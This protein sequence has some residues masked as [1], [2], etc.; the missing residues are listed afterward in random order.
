MSILSWVL[1]FSILCGVFFE[2]VTLHRATVH[3]QKRWLKE[4]E[5]QTGRLLTKPTLGSKYLLK[6]TIEFHLK[7]QL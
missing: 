2:A 1:S 5:I 4:T 6:Q 7:G 3:R